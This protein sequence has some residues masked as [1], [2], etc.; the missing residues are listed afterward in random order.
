MSSNRGSA[1]ICC[2]L[3]GKRWREE[4]SCHLTW[5]HRRGVDG[6]TVIVDLSLLPSHCKEDDCR[7]GIRLLESHRLLLNGRQVLG[8]L[9]IDKELQTTLELQPSHDRLSRQRL[10]QR[11]ETLG[12]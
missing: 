11:S 1:R 2:L 9:S 4:P 7:H 6:Y 3:F 8:N 12:P 5:D 10:F